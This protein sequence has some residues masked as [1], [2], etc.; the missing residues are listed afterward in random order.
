M[1]GRHSARPISSPCFASD[2]FMWTELYKHAGPF[3][4]DSQMAARS[5][6]QADVGKPDAPTGSPGSAPCP[7]QHSAARHH[8]PHS[9]RVRERPCLPPLGFLIAH[10]ALP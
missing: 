4:L 8:M 10:K 6:L 5:D 2:P 1:S 3:G 9:W 7:P